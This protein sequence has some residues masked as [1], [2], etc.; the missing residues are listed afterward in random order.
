MSQIISAQTTGLPRIAH[1]ER[2]TFETDISLELNLD[3]SGQCKIST[4]SGFFDHML[5]AFSRHSGFDIT[6]HVIGDLQV[7]D[8]HTVE[9]VGIVLGQAFSTALGDKK[10]ITRFGDVLIPMDEALVYAAVDISG[11]G[12]LHYRV[13]VPVVMI[14]NFESTLAEEFFAAFCSKAGVT[15]HLESFAGKNTHHILEV[16]FKSAARALGLAASI[17]PRIK[18]IPSTKGSL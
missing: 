6:A 1:V 11:R 8:H 13:D 4:G 12:Q 5:V 10:G 2:K 14:G 16:T 3:G 7:D 17:D 9:D 15:L 18:G